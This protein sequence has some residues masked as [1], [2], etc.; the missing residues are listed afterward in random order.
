MS[1]LSLTYA[2]GAVRLQPGG[3]LWLPVSGHERDLLFDTAAAAVP[4]PRGWLP[5]EGGLVANLRVWE[6]CLLPLSYFGRPP[7]MADEALFQR[8]L[9]GLAMSMPERA[10]F[11]A[12]PAGSLTPRLRRLACGLRALLARPA[13]LLAESEWFSRLDEVDALN[14]AGLFAEHCPHSA[15]L[16][17]GGRRPA[18]CW[19]F[20]DDDNREA[21]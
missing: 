11:A 10:A 9:D 12:S 19:G 2:G 6:N 18:A 1:L 3:R 13:L 21:S 15:W 17:L 8:L 7:A 14:L 5:G 20:T 4:G 16:V